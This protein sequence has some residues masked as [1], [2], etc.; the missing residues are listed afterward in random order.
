MKYRSGTSFTVP[1]TEKRPPRE[2]FVS[3]IGL[4]KWDMNLRVLHS[5][6]ENG[7]AF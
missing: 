1:F 7:T 3:K 6:E 5:N 2:K 4:D